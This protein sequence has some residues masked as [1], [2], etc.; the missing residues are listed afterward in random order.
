[1]KAEDGEAVINMVFF[2]DV[3]TDLIGKPPDVLINEFLA[4]NE[5]LPSDISRLVGRRVML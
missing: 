4:S 5:V 3:A 1:V 2:G